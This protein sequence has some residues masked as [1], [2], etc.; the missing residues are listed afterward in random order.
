MDK[1]EHSI[2]RYVMLTKEE[3]DED[4]IRKAGHSLGVARDIQRSFSEDIT[5]SELR[6]RWFP[7]RIVRV[8]EMT[9][10]TIEEV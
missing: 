9:H 6:E 1:L 5:N 2:A 8:I 4:A 3:P 7:T 10:T